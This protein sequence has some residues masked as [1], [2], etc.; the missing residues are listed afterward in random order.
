MA[1]ATNILS[2][3]G[4][5]AAIK[6]AQVEGKPKKIKD[7][8]GLILDVRPTGSGWWRLR[9]WL[10]GAEGMVSLGTY[11]E[12]SLAGARARR[13]DARKLVAKGINPSAQ[14]KADKDIQR[15]RAAVEKIIAKGAPVP[16]SFE[17]VARE[18]LI[19]VHSVKVSAGHAERTRIRFENDIFPFIGTRPISEIEAP[20]L[21]ATLRRIEARG[22][23]ETTHRAK[24][25]C[26]Q[27]FRYGIASGHCSR[28]PAA[29]LRDALAPVP[30]RHHAAIVAPED[31]GKLLRDM[32]AYHG[33]PL[34]RAALQ[35]S[36]LLMLRP[37]E[38]RQLEWAWLNFET[39]ML[40]IPSTLM[41]RSKE[42][43]A[44]GTPH[45]VP[46]ARQTIAILRDDI[47]PLTGGGR[48][49][50]T[51]LLTADRPMSN[52]TVRTALR[53]LGYGNDDMTAHGFR[54]VARTLIAEG[55]DIAPE[56]VEA[57][58]AHAVK[59]ANGRAYNRTQYLR[60]RAEMMQ[61]WADY[62]DKLRAGADVIPLRA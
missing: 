4:I 7:G 6:V 26:G 49:V 27:V 54:A 39:A 44:N 28:N 31:V 3:K 60:Q 32:H 23:I 62:L 58:L 42:E 46:L 30:T 29:D 47:A 61:R 25:A 43:K 40:T 12:V 37:G 21:L 38:L 56:I 22:A 17:A 34:T 59:D 53:R 5:K 11:P 51:S 14:R 1:T 15:A 20:E 41:K 50:F 8:G 36:A 13:D 57:Q 48:F 55:L 16:G 10:N 18:W 33:H 45:H 19:T 24:D 9:Y 35:L 52:N 2:D